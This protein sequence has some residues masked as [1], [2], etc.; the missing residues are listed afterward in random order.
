[1]TAED[2]AR[3]VHTELEAAL[4]GVAEHAR[5]TARLQRAR[6][7]EESARGAA[8]QARAQAAAE[9]RDVRAL[10][11]FSPTRIWA[12]LRGSRDTDLDR[13]EAERQAAEYAAARAEAWLVSTHDEVRRAEAELAALGD[14]HGRRERATAAKEQWVAEAGGPTGEE[15][16]RIADELASSSAAAKEVREALAAGEQAA[17]ALARASEVLGS[18]GSWA[19]YDTFF[20]GG[21]IT[22]MVKYDRMDEAQRLLHGAD[23]ALRRLSAEL[24]DVGMTEVVHGLSVDGLTQAFDVWFDNIFTDW[25]V[26]SRITEAARRT[27]EAAGVVH[28]IRTRLA[29]RQRDL[30]TRV[31]EL[32]AQRERLLVEATA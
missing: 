32:T 17:A 19:T 15:L 11:S 7:S 18:A 28:E 29:G 3:Q 4:E 1:M 31:A 6:Q 5:V 10:E 9:T 23:Q 25:S 2:R 24:A 12:T 21:L 14:V 16:G 27:A 22:D 8:V 26:K 13:E 20:G 30:D